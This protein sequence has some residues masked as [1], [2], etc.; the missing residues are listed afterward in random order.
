MM[1]FALNNQRGAKQRTREAMISLEGHSTEICLKCGAGP[2]DLGRALNRHKKTDIC[3]T[4]SAQDWS[5]VCSATFE[6]AGALRTHV[7]CGAGR[8]VC[9]PRNKNL[10]SEIPAFSGFACAG[11][12]S[13]NIAASSGAAAAPRF[14]TA[15]SMDVNDSPQGWAAPHLRYYAEQCRRSEALRERVSINQSMPGYGAAVE[16]WIGVMQEARLTRLPCSSVLV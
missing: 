10:Y 7:D 11:E 8:R 6:S 13:A 5:C 9:A 4:Y 2:F 12:T 16:D 1:L 15:P 14:T 3:K